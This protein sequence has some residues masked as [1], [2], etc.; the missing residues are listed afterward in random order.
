MAVI[1]T[2]KGE[3]KRMRQVSCVSLVL[4]PSGQKVHGMNANENK[5]HSDKIST[6]EKMTLQNSFCLTVLMFQQTTSIV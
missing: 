5:Q 2:K 1:K 3:E 4:S 6:N